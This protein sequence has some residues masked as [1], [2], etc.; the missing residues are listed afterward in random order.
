M[1]EIVTQIFTREEIDNLLRKAYREKYKIGEEVSVFVTWRLKDI[2][3]SGPCLVVNGV[4]VSPALVVDGVRV[5]QE[6]DKP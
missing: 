3:Q 5:S 4:R 1:T 6:L 2:G